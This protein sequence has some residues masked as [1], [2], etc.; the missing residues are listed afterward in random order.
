LYLARGLAGATS[1]TAV[2]KG[3]VRI[4]LSISISDRIGGLWSWKVDKDKLSLETKKAKLE[5]A[6]WPEF[7]DIA[8][9]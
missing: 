3:M 9:R 5:A 7:A 1:G 8:A 4:V 6:Q 2:A